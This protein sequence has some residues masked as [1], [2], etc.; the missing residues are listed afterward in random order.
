MKTL[1]FS[2][3]LCIALI[4]VCVCLLSLATFLQLAKETTTE[5][6]NY[7]NLKVPILTRAG[8]TINAVEVADYIA[9]KE[10]ARVNRDQQAALPEARPMKSDC[11]TKDDTQ[12]E[13]AEDHQAPDLPEVTI[14]GIKQSTILNILVVGL[15]EAGKTALVNALLGCEEGDP[16]AAKEGHEIGGPCPRQVKGR[17]TARPELA[18]LCVWDSPGLDDGATT[19]E[20][21]QYLKEIECV[22]KRLSNHDIVIVCIKANARFVEGRHNTNIRMMIKLRKKFGQNFWRKVVIALTFADTVELIH[23]EWKAIENKEQKIEKFKETIK[24]YEAEIKMNM[25]RHVG[26]DKEIVKKIKLVPTGHQSEP[27]LLDREHWYTNLWIACLNTIPAI[28]VQ[29]SSVFHNQDRFVTGSKV[30]PERGANQIVLGPDFIPKELLKSKRESATRG[31]LIGMLGGPFSVLGI[32]LGV[33]AGGRRGEAE[34]TD[35]LRRA[36]EKS[37]QENSQLDRDCYTV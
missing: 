21:K 2:K 30:T 13:N 9:A 3:E 19:V 29:P 6:Q 16:E 8:A 11:A 36:R 33:W 37:V 27:M 23:P 7:T 20:K 12:L 25:E 10:Q 17:A 4:G 28:E 14:S 5:T 22:W 24:E 18:G 32:P 26:I 15:T 35:K 34:Y 1:S 31:G